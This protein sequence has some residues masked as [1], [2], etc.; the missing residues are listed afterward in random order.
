[1]VKSGLDFLILRLIEPLS[2]YLLNLPGQFSLSGPIVLNWA[3]ATLKELIH[4]QNM[5]FY[6]TFHHHLKVKNDLFKS[7]STYKMSSR[8]CALSRARVVARLESIPS[9]IH[10][11]V[12]TFI[13]SHW[14][15]ILKGFW[16]L[17]KRCQH[18]GGQRGK[19]LVKI[20]WRIWHKKCIWIRISHWCHMMV[21][22]AKFWIS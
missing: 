17:H 13:K 8:W 16:T 9:L 4:I 21:D 15:Q 6:F 20:C 11:G 18:Y 7:Y 12:R 22:G 5:K 19:S 10:N 1:M 3:A 2:R 14:I